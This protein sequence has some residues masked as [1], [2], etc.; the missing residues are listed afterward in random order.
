MWDV[1]RRTAELGGH[2]R[3]GV[4]DTFYLP[5]GERTRGNGELI[6]NLVRI[7]RECGRDCE[8]R[9]GARRFYLGADRLQ[10]RAFL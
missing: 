6:E 1:H 9:R 3:T 4:E 10:A 7:A 5:N 8:P 2:L